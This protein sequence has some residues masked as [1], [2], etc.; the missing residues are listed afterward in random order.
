MN[1]TKLGKTSNKGLE[2][3]DSRRQGAPPVMKKPSSSLSTVRTEVEARL[4]S[5][6]TLC[7]M[8]ERP[9][10]VIMGLAAENHRK[11]SPQAYSDNIVDETIPLERVDGSVEVCLIW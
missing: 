8:K 7:G 3:G 11:P 9:A 2:L 10:P 1:F 4:Q 6:N 5:H